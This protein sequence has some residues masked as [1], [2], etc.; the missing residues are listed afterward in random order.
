MRNSV[1]NKDELKNIIKRINAVTNIRED[2]LEKDYYVCLLLKDLSNKQDQL[3]AYF[4]GGTAVYKIL[5]NNIRFSE[6]VDLTVKVCDDESNTQNRKRFKK[7]ALG[8]EIE[9][10]KLNEN[11]TIDKKGTITSFYEYETVTNNSVLLKPEF[12]QV[13]ATSFTVSEPVKKYTIEPLIYK[14]AS[15]DEK[16]ILKNKFE[17]SEFDI[18]IIALERIFI[19]KIFAAEFYYIRKDYND[20]SKHLFDISILLYTDEIQEFLKNTEYVK[21]VIEYKR[22]EELV[23]LGGI[24]PNLKI[25]DFSYLNDSFNNDVIKKFYFIQNEYVYMDEQKLKI[26]EVVNRL[27]VIKD[28]MIKIGE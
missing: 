28:F 19:D 1:L 13:E 27:K 8:Y 17:I 12:V 25:K 16:A 20:L 7:S 21:K 3:K 18:E 14:Y 22:Q 24:D 4:K 23:R 11:L 10:L 6:D 26:E 5:D 2:I 9:G 15:C